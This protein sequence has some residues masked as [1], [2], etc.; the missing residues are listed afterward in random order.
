MYEDWVADDAFKPLTALLVEDDSYTRKAIAL[1]LEI[2]G[3]G[4]VVVAENGAKALALLDQDDAKADV[5]FCDIEMP[6]LSGHEFVRRVRYGIVPWFKDVP[7]FML[8]AHDTDKNVQRGRIHRSDG[9]VVKPLSPE[10]LADCLRKA[11]AL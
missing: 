11:L 1:L 9:F 10:V 2:V 7:I 5:V 8:T 6:E 4:N 3:A